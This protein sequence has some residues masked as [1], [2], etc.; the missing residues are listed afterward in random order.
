VVKTEISVFMEQVSN[1]GVTKALKG[2]KVYKT[3]GR[4]TN[5][6]NQYRFVEIEDFISFDKIIKRDKGGATRKENSLTLYMAE[7]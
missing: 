2:L 4:G 3:T 1:E 6:I 5:R 7:L